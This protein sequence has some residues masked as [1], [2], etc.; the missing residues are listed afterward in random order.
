MPKPTTA[1]K[2]SALQSSK[3]PVKLN[4][5]AAQA[6]TLR[7]NAGDTVFP[8]IADK[9]IAGLRQKRAM[10]QSAKSAGY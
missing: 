8:V 6:A 4:P 1:A 10:A 7:K 5:I 3:S 9:M 2:T